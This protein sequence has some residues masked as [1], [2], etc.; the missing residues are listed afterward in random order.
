MRMEIGRARASGLAFRPLAQT[1]RETWAWAR[2]HPASLPGATGVAPEREA[3]LLSLA[4]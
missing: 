1:V 4:G 2:E 3:E